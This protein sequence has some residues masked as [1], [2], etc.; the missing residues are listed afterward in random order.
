LLWVHKSY[1][2]TGAFAII[3]TTET[4]LWKEKV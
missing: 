1:I 4:P 2:F 3:K